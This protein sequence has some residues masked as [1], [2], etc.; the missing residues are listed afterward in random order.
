MVNMLVLAIIIDAS[1]PPSIFLFT[2]SHSPILFLSEFHHPL[3]REFLR[4]KY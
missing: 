4:R 2:T 3:L 1:N